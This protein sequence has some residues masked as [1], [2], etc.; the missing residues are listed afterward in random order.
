MSTALGVTERTLGIVHSLDVSA[1]IGADLLGRFTVGRFVVVTP[2][3]DTV[4][5]A[6]LLLMA[7]EQAGG[8]IG[9]INGIRWTPVPR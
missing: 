8:D 3:V 9:R 2:V 5:F 1:E 4:M 6:T 7:I